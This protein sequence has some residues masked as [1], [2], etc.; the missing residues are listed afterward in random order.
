MVSTTRIDVAGGRSL[1]VYEAGD[2][3]GAPILYHH[4][5]PSSEAPSEPDDRLAAE[6]KVRLVSW[7]RV[8]YGESS[9]NRGRDV[10][11]AAEEAAA[12][13]DAL[14]I[15]RCASWGLSGGGP[16]AL[17]CAALLPDRIAAVA[18]VAGI[19]PHGAEGL[20]W[21][22][23]MGEANVQEFGA[24][25][26]G[27]ETLRPALEAEASGMDST[28]TDELV[29]A[30]STLLSPPD[31]AVLDGAYGE[32]LLGNFKRALAHGIDRWVDDDLAFTRPWGFEPAEIG[33]PV[34]V[35]QGR[36]DFMVPGGHGD[37]L[38]AQIPGAEAWFS[39]DEG[40]LTLAQP[41][42]VRR[43][44]EWLLERL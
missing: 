38:A 14:A 42:S 12:I 41:R 43:I 18:S 4:G 31:V 7:D 27:E 28:T 1:T 10:A 33:P 19:A 24:S 35:V 37:W 26:A 29:A 20:D 13:L 32:Y 17:A 16:H 3:G 36:Q 30:M 8:G 6:Q 44:N 11:A 39:E 21:L 40:H 25:L 22:G 34:L 15:E 9:R 2:P 23:G 5:T